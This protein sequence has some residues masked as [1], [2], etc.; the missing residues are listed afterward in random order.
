M[1]KKFIHTNGEKLVHC[2]VCRGVLLK[3]QKKKGT[4]ENIALLS[5]R[6]PH[7]GKETKLEMKNIGDDFFV[8][9]L[10]AGSDR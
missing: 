2:P 6:C 1:A 10:E 3:V 5:M 8:D 4:S 7:C 9:I